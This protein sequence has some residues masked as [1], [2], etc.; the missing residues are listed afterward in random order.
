MFW[1]ILFGLVIF[2]LIWA[3][4][5]YED[6]VPL[7]VFSIIFLI[8]VM[9]YVIGSGVYTYVNLVSKETAV[10]SLQQEVGKI[11]SDFKIPV[12][13]LEQATKYAEAKAEYNAL[14]VETQYK[15]RSPFY[16]WFSNTMFVSDKVM[17]LKPIE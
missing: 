12:Q 1:I 6:F 17:E 7:A 10:K 13:N 9:V 8:I 4:T 3:G 11:S 2:L 5:E 15:K 16:F 14:L